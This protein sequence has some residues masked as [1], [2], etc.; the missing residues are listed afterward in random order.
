ATSIDSLLF[1]ISV[2]LTEE[3]RLRWQKTV[4]CRQSGEGRATLRVPE[5]V[6]ESAQRSS[7]RRTPFLPGALLLGVSPRNKG[8]FVCLDARTGAQAWAG[9]SRQGENAAIVK[10]GEKLFSLTT[11]AE[12]I[13]SRI[14][15]NGLELLKRYTVAG[16]PT[17]AHT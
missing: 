14:S 17:W 8:Q 2:L 5:K 6:W 4:G 1:E 12:L 15:S 11:D 10:A 7:Y 9:D 13:V 3:R 16:S